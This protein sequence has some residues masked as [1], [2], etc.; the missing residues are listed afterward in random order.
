[1]KMSVGV[2]TA[3]AGFFM[4]S[5]CKL[6]AAASKRAEEAKGGMSPQPHRGQDA[7]EPSAK[8][9][10]LLGRHTWV[11]HSCIREHHQCVSTQLP[12]LPTACICHT[13]VFCC[14]AAC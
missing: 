7:G 1:M 6:A 10:R 12:G 14:H 4:Y 13:N 8:M 2:V 11:P 5:H 9:L 3:M